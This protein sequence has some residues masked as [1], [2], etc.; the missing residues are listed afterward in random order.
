MVLIHEIGVRFSVGSQKRELVRA[1]KKYMLNTILLIIVICWLLYIEYKVLKRVNELDKKINDV[2]FI[3]RQQTNTAVRTLIVYLKQKDILNDRQE[4]L[5]QD[6]IEMIHRKSELQL[7]GIYQ[8]P[9][10]EIF[11]TKK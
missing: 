7:K 5:L 4:K 3:S 8:S 2:S 10:D 6:E 11:R 9:L 1:L